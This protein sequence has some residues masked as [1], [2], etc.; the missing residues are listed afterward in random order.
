M[1]LANVSKVASSAELSGR[2]GSG[3]LSGTMFVGLVKVNMVT[4][5]LFDYQHHSV[6][7]SLCHEI[8]CHLEH[9]D[10]CL[11]VYTILGR[12]KGVIHVRSGIVSE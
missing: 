2:Q 3:V 11:A 5:S 9:I 6:E 1:A 8:A 12:V 4:G 7:E 10:H